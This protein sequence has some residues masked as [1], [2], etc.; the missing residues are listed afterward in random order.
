MSNMKKARLLIGWTQDQMAQ[1]LGISSRML[2]HYEK[3]RSIPSD[4]LV[5]MHKL[6]GQSTDYLLGLTTKE[7]SK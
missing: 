2:R 6:T 4:L 5:A 3:G 1:R 7:E